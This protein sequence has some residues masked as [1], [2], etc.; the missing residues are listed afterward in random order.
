LLFITDLRTY[1]AP[2]KPLCKMNEYLTAA[3]MQLIFVFY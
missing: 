1:I 3:E 2:P